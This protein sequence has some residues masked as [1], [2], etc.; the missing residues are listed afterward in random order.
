MAFREKSGLRWVS[1]PSEI[2]RL[3]KVGKPHRAGPVSLWT[4]P[5]P[6]GSTGLPT[7]GVVAGRGFKGAV[8]RNLAR[9]RTKGAVLELRELLAEDRCYLVECRPGAES[10]NYQKLVNILKCLITG[11]GDS[12]NQ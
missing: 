7:A 4:A 1:S 12:E 5:A 2:R 9:R 8:S 6:E 11:T 3:R 10:L